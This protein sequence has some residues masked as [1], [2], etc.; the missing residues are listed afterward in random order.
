ML[1]LATQNDATWRV[2]TLE[3]ERGGR[4]YTVDT[5][6]QIHVELPDATLFF[7]MGTDT[8]RDV[9][10]WREP[11][12]IFRLAT[13]LVVRRAGEPEPDVAALGRLCTNETQP[14]LI[15]MPAVDISSSEIRRRIAENEP[16]DDVVPSAVAEFIARHALYR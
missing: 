5:L 8:L 12:E 11:G 2:C 15:E 3:I 10:H 4:S 6:R 1:R 13:P 16:I 14:R 7:L 9:R